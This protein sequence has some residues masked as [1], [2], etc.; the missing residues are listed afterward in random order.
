MF[1]LPNGMPAQCDPRSA[2]VNQANTTK[3]HSFFEIPVAFIFL[4]SSA[5]NHSTFRN[6][7]AVRKKVGV[8]HQCSIANVQVV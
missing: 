5:Y 4:M 2:K 7:R 8:V 3:V 1:K 6:T